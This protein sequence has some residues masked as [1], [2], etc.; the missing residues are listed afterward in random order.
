MLEAIDY[1]K[2]AASNF[3]TA[4]SYYEDTEVSLRSIL[5]SL[6]SYV[7][8]L[9]KFPYDKSLLQE[10]QDSN[11]PDNQPASVKELHPVKP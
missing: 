6:E 2:M 5:A 1:F 3:K 4:E 10:Q 11:V 8:L 9:K 7:E